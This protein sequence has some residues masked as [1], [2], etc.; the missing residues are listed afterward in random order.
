MRYL[1]D[2]GLSYDGDH[3]FTLSGYTDADWAGSVSDRKSTSGC[4]FS[5]RSAMISWQSRKQS[6][7]SLSTEEEEYIAACSA[8]CEAR[9]LRKLLIDLFDLEMRATLILCDN[10]SCIKMT[11]NLVFHDRSKHIEIR[12]HYIRDMVQRGALKLQY[13]STDEHVA[14]VLTKPLS[15]IK[16][17]YFQDKL[18]I[19][20]KDPPRKG[21]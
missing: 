10:H 8:S 15:R 5:L 1:I 7:I 11:E 16:F 20:R 3:D 13:I 19:V 6:S 4:C 12:Y 2:C 21:E 18:G 17:E 14:G 9:W